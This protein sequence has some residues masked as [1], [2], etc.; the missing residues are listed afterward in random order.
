MW[1]EKWFS[2]ND[3]GSP[4]FLDQVPLEGFFREKLIHAILYD[5][6]IP[7]KNTLLLYQGLDLLFILGFKKFG[8]DGIIWHFVLLQQ[9]FWSAPKTPN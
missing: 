1:K 4:N 7:F 5:F 6:N 8:I 9:M 2:L 3:D